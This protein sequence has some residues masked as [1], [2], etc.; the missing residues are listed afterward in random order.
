MAEQSKKVTTY[1]QPAA[2]SMVSPDAG[3]M[4]ALRAEVERLK[5]ENAALTAWGFKAYTELLNTKLVLD[6]ASLRNI[7]TLL[8]NAPDGVKGDK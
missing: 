7:K 5:A 1:T 4:N 6:G 8:D 2:R 3:S